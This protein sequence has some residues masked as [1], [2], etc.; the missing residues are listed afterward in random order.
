MTRLLMKFACLAVLAGLVVLGAGSLSAHEDHDGDADDGA[1]RNMKLVGFNDLQA[2][3]TYQPTLHKQGGR[4]YIYAGHH[5]YGA[6]GEGS[7]PPGTPPL[8]KVNN[9]ENGTSIVDVTNPR[10]P[11]YVIH[12]P[13]PNGTGGGAQMVRVCDGIGANVGKVFMLRSYGNTAHE[14][15]DVTMPSSPMGVRTVA[16][17]NPVIGAGTGQPGAL[18]GTHKSWWECDTGIAYVVGRRGNDTASG[19]KGGNHIF[20]FDLSN[21]SNPVFLRDW[22]LDG[23]QPGGGPPPHFT[24]VPSI[25][26]PISTGPNA[27]TNPIYGTGATLDRVYFAYGTGST[28]VMQIVDRTK[29][30]P[31]PWGTGVTCGSAASSL[32]PTPCTDFKTAELGRWIMNPDNGAHTS[33]PI[34]K[35]PIQDFITDTGNTDLGTPR[36]I[37]FVTSEATANYCAGQVRHLSFTVDATDEGR[38]QSIA[39]YQVSAASG[40]F[41]DRGGRFGPHA[42]NEEF[43]GP[44][45]QKLVFTSQFNAGVRV[46]DVRD[47][48][49][50]K[51]AAFFI[52]AVNANTDLRCGPF[53]GNPNKCV[54]A[55]QT[56]NVAS[57]DRGFVYIVDRADSGMHVLR[58]TGEAARIA[59]L[60]GDD[61]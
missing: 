54:Q 49:N 1:S 53:Q 42:T 20:V 35:I 22:A 48:Y 36:D 41:C 11:K 13:V 16:G 10:H 9:E 2:R 34:G 4:Y 45:Y 30:L 8:P 38:P 52:P 39:T 17:G 51:E 33:F 60:N 27:T 14:I 7:A 28:G 55:V 56:N 50:L 61:D 23:Q 15:W 57:D 46:T 6:P 59:G 19:W 32:L 12:I 47:P 31:P 43:G 37:V 40:R 5:A 25:H 3:S 44:F 24:T 21:P 26:G 58:L 29:L 18:A